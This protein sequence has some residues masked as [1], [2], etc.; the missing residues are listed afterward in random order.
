MYPPIPAVM[1]QAVGPDIFMGKYH[2]PGGTKLI[3]ALFAMMRWVK[4]ICIIVR[5]AYVLKN[6]DPKYMNI[7]NDMY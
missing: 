3:I 5:F 4:F 6:I 1:R 2:I 7:I